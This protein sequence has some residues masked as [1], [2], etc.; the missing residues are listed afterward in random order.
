MSLKPPPFGTS[1]SASGSTG[2]FV[3]DV[4]DE[5][6]NQHIVLVLRGIHAAAQFV[7]AFPEGVIEFRFL[8]GHKNGVEPP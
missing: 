2:V 7:A 3:G 1:I 5:Q 8:Y 4:F 6:Q